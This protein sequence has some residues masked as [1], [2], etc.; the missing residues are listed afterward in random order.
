MSDSGSCI[1]PT[2]L[3]P[4][5]HSMA[6]VHAKCSGAFKEE[7]GLFVSLYPELRNSFPQ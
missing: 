2:D 5:F 4:R 1:Q 3:I 6:T 7:T